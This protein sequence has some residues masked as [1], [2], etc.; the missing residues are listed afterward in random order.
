VTVPTLAERRLVPDVQVIGTATDTGTSPLSLTNPGAA[1]GDLIVIG[2]A[3]VNSIPNAAGPDGAGFTQ[4]MNF[5]TASNEW[6]T[7]WYKIA[8]SEAGAWSYTHSAGAV[9][10]AA[11]VVYRGA[12]TLV[13]AATRTSHVDALAAW[14]ATAT[15]YGLHVVAFWSMDAGGLDPNITVVGPVTED[16]SV[17]TN[18]SSSCEVWLGHRMLT[19]AEWERGS[20]YAFTASTA[21]DA[22][23]SGGASAIFGRS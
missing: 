8:S 15:P 7:L 22:D 10:A 16:V 11:A 21:G 1:D 14:G 4:I 6:E 18:P 9:A 17:M 2:M 3:T 12:G 19:Q 5:D 20:T 13:N 23:F